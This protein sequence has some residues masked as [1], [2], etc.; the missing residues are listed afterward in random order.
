[1]PNFGATCLLGQTGVAAA[2]TAQKT[3]DIDRAVTT[4]NFYKTYADGYYAAYTVYAQ[5]LVAAGADYQ[6]QAAD[7]Q[8]LAD[9]A[10]AQADTQWWTAMYTARA[11]VLMPLISYNL[12]W[13]DFQIALAH[14]EADGATSI[15]PQYVE[16]QQAITDAQASDTYRRR[17]ASEPLFIRKRL[18][19]P[20][21]MVETEH[22][23][24]CSRP[25][26]RRYPFK[27]VGAPSLPV[28]GVRSRSAR[29]PHDAARR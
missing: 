9:V 13:V 16:S 3:Y 11:G 19:M 12:P 22:W 1:M 25:F 8:Q 5:S 18:S 28:P 7:A 4:A 20:L 15:A 26:R 2:G 6:R 23:W 21:T 10:T 24:P 14:A 17:P 29:V 27:A